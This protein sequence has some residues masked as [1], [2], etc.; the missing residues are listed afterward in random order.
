[1]N[2]GALKTFAHFI[3]IPGGGIIENCPLCIVLFLTLQIAEFKD[4]S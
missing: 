2:L 3:I 1:M 4:L